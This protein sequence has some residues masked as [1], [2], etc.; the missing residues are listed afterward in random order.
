MLCQIYDFKWILIGAL[1]CRNEQHLLCI[2][3]K[4]YSSSLL[5][6]LHPVQV[7][8]LKIMSAFT[9]QLQYEIMKTSSLWWA[10]TAETILT[11][12][13]FGVF[14]KDCSGPWDDMLLSVKAH[15]DVMLLSW[16]WK[17]YEFIFLF[18]FF[19]FL[20]HGNASFPSS[21]SDS[22]IVVWVVV[23]HLHGNGRLFLMH[24]GK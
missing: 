19:L 2:Y 7:N 10:F 1:I 12:R 23:Y 9:S 11:L 22:K 13:F 8:Y 15:A 24:L 5:V 4:L 20:R 21:F 6:M 18:F 3:V 16:L 17:C 14:F